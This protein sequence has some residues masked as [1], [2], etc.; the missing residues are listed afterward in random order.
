MCYA[1][2][3]PS[4]LIHRE[5]SF[6]FRSCF[7]IFFFFISVRGSA[8]YDSLYQRVIRPDQMLTVP[9]PSSFGFERV[10]IY[11]TWHLSVPQQKKKSWQNQ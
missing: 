1:E 8:E 9:Y 7:F 4:S 2:I 6:C 11:T 5:W 10:V 3:A